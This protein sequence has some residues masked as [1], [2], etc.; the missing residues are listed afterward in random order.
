M[1]WILTNGV[2]EVLLSASG[3][4]CGYFCIRTMSCLIQKPGQYAPVGIL[5]SLLLQIL[6]AALHFRFDMQIEVLSLLFFLTP[7]PS[8][9][10]QANQSKTQ[11]SNLIKHGLSEIRLHAFFIIEKG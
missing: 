5:L 3:F 6:D 7:C 2:L 10:K 9:C 1:V 4:K 11:E 8:L